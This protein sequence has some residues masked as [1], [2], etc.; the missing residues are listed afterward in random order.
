MTDKLNW[1]QALV[2]IKDLESKHGSMLSVNENDE[3]L[4]EIRFLL[5]GNYMRK[6]VDLSLSEKERQKIIKLAQ[7]GYTTKDISEIESLKH[8]Y[9]QQVRLQEQ[10]KRRKIFSYHLKKSEKNPAIYFSSLAS[11][12]FLLHSAYVNYSCIKTKA[13]KYGF[14]L[15][16]SN[17]LF[18][19]IRNG[20]YYMTGGK[21]LYCKHGVDSYE[22]DIVE[23]FS[24]I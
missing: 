6:D 16:R 2:K 10:I 1:A 3:E 13:D 9:I 21:T 22:R 24:L 20:D 19:R 14:D 17:T 8:Y 15:V 4:K 11:V 5:S 23:K 12:G 18:G 7:Y